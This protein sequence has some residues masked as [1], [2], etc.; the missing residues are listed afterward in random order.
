MPPLLLLLPVPSN[1]TYE[2]SHKLTLAQT[3]RVPLFQR[4]TRPTYF[5]HT[6]T[7]MFYGIDL[8]YPLSF[9]LSNLFNFRSIWQKRLNMIKKNSLAG[10]KVSDRDRLMLGK[11]LN[12]RNQSYRYFSP[13]RFQANSGLPRSSFGR[14]PRSRSVSITHTTRRPP[15]LTTTISN[16]TTAWT[17]LTA[18][19]AAATSPRRSSRPSLRPAATFTK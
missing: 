8:E 16:T 9:I 19:A 15:G 3:Y 10:A 7:S 4:N 1:G 6:P 5:Y 12:V 11:R 13:S 18:A 14:T 17:R 2:F